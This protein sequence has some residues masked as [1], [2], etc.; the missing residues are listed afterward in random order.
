M[1]VAKYSL[2]TQAEFARLCAMQV[3][4]LETSVKFKHKK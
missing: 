4:L 1:F 3:L 2:S